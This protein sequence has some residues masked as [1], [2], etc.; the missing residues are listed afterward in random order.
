[1]VILSIVSITHEYL[2]P[3]THSIVCKNKVN[4]RE[5][6]AA[7]GLVTL[8]DL[9]D[10]QIGPMAFLPSP[11]QLCVSFHSHQ[12]I[13][14][15][16]TV[17]KHSNRVKIGIL[18]SPITLKLDRWHWKTIGHLPYASSSFMHHF[19]VINVLK[20][21]LQSGNAQI[22]PILVILCLLWPWHFID[23]LEKQ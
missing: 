23:D 21:E 20:F 3:V 12:C 15:G 6:I 2:S 10:L 19:E 1:M 17:W 16:L 4:L 8:F 5:S 22:G 18:L 14:L 13:H 9:C 11:F 7:T